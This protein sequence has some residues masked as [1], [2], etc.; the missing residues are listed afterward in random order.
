MYVRRTSSEELEGDS[1]MRTSI[2]KRLFSTAS[3]PL[4]PII[5]LRRRMLAPIFTTLAVGSLSFVAYEVYRFK[6]PTEQLPMDPALPTVIILGSGWASCS[7]LIDLDT[8]NYNVRKGNLTTGKQVIVVSPRNYFLFTPLLPSCTVGTIEVR[9]IMEPI[10]YITRHKKRQV[11][12][13]EA[14]CINIDH[15]RKE[16]TVKDFSEI[17]ADLPQTLKV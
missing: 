4:K 7:F 17:A 12:F 6:N 9:S 8:T 15:E 16:I 2:F 1:H 5:P 11:S 10:R 14:E 3:P 13:V